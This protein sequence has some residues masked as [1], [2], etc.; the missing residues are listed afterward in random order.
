MKKKKIVCAFFM[1][2]MNF[3]AYKIDMNYLLFDAFLITY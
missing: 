2:A 1:L 3:I